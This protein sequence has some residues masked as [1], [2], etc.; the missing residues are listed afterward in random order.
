[1]PDA[2]MQKVIQDVKLTKREQRVLWG[3]FKRIDRDGSG[4]ID[5]EEFLQWLKQPKNS[6]TTGLFEL[7]DTDSNNSLD[8]FEF[9]HALV[10]FGAYARLLS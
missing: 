10:T 9:V 3:I 7:I 5:V 1:M 8:F 4:T 6:F 2:R